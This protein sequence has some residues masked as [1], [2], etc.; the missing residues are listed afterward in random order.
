MSLSFSNIPNLLHKRS[1]LKYPLHARFVV[2]ESNSAS[3]SMIQDLMTALLN[4][5][6]TIR[7]IDA[8]AQ[9]GI[10]G[11]LTAVVIFL[12]VVKLHKTGMDRS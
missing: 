6:S 7:G 11:E 10:S 3:K 5:L 12:Q 1:E 9:F 2:T 4:S 8:V